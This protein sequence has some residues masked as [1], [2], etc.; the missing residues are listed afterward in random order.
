[1]TKSLSRLILITVAAAVVMSGC[2]EFG[3]PKEPRPVPAI[4][5]KLTDGREVNLADFKGKPLVIGIGATWCLHCMHEAPI[6]GR[7]Y[8]RYKGQ[9][10]MLGII[11]KSPPKDAEELVRKSKLDFMIAL[12]PDGSIAKQLGVSGYP[13]SFFIN[14]EG[15]IVDDNFGGVEQGELY[16]KI[17]NLLKEK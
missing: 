17:D 8:A 10:N 15:C 5:L 16:K 14:R 12:D 1:M 4:S 2:A 7:A 11:A 9:I 6:F 13:S 3:K